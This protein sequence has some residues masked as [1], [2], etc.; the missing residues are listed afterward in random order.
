MSPAAARTTARRLV[1][2]VVV[3]TG[4][5]PAAAAAGSLALDGPTGP[6]WW[7]V[8]LLACFTLAHVA[9]VVA[10]VRGTSPDPAAAAFVVVGLLTAVSQAAL[11]GAGLALPD[12]AVGHGPWPAY[13][14]ATATQACAVLARN[15]P[16][17]W[18][19]LATTAF[20]ALVAAVT[21]VPPPLPQGGAAAS[22]VYGAVLAL[23][24]ATVYYL[25]RGL[26]QTTGRVGAAR[27]A[28]L[29]ADAEAE[30]M[31]L[32]EAERGRWEAAVHDDVLTA[33]RAGASA[34]TQREVR[35][36]AAAAS[37]ALVSIAAAPAT[38]TVGSALAAQQV[39][40]AARGAFDRAVVELSSTPGALPGR[41]V[42]AVADA[43]A[44]LMRNTV[45]HNP[46]GVRARVH[47]H[48]GEAG[49]RVVVS[50]DGGGFDTGALP[51]GRL[52]IRVSVVGRMRSVGGDADVT[53]SRRGTTVELRW[54]R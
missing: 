33:L 50:D 54:P 22:V 15:A 53:S 8:P 4:A 49:A 27:G 29:R 38:L 5:S 31:A 32:A 9:A 1:G 30:A 6:L 52:G 51:T 23:V 45:H 17:S 37:A 43:T 44:E 34:E 13:V 21:P 10:V 42:E 48:L 28:V 2:T 41:V 40:A 39:A 11:L 35:D 20:S 47:G 14:V 25:A 19:L 26:E 16:R 46:P 36:A 12:P 3:L 7:A 24:A 18:G